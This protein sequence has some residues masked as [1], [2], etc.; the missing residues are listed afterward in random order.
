MASLL[1]EEC[2]D[3]RQDLLKEK[4]NSTNWKGQGFLHYEVVRAILTQS[5]VLAWSRQHPLCRK[6]Q[7]VCPKLSY[8]ISQITED[9]VLLFVVL[10]LSQ[11]EYLFEELEASVTDHGMLFDTKAFAQ[12]CKSTGLSERDRL[13]FYDGRLQIKIAEKYIRPDSGSSKSDWEKLLRE[14]RTLRQR[15]NHANII[16]LLAAYQQEIDESGIPVKTLHLL[17]PWGEGDLKEWINQRQTPSNVKALNRKERQNF[18]YRCIYGLVSGV[19]YLHSEIEG[20][21]T[22]HH[23]LKPGNILWVGG[24]LKIADF[25]HSHVRSVIEGS[26]T[27]GV[28]EVGTYEYHPPEYWN[29]DG[30]RSEG[31]P[32][33]D[34]DVW[35]MGC[36][37]IELLILV[38][39]GWET[40]EIARFARERHDS[41][42]P[43]RKKTE[44][45]LADDDSSF[46]NSLKVVDAWT[47]VLYE[48]RSSDHPERLVYVRM[49]AIAMLN[50]NPED[51]P[52]MWESQMDLYNILRQHD[53]QF[54]VIEKDLCVPPRARALPKGTWLAVDTP[55]HRAVRKKDFKRT[56][57]LWELGWPLSTRNGDNDRPLRMMAASEDSRLRSL[58]NDVSLMLK[59]ASDGQIDLLKQLFSRGLSPLMINKGG[60]SA[61]HQTIS[62]FQPVDSD[63]DSLTRDRLCQRNLQLLRTVEFLLETKGNDQVN[64]RAGNL[65]AGG[66]GFPL[67][68]AASKGFVEAM[69]RILQEGA[70]INGRAENDHLSPLYL[71]ASKCHPGAVKLLLEHKAKVRLY[72]KPHGTTP[73]HGALTKKMDEGKVCEVV[74]C[75]LE[76]D[77]GKECIDFPEVMMG[78]PL[79]MA[80]SLE[81]LKCCRLLTDY[82]A[83]VHITK[84]NNLGLLHAIARNGWTDFLQQIHEEFSLEELE[85]RA[86]LDGREFRAGT[87]TPAEVAKKSGHKQI[88]RL[89]DTRRHKLKRLE[90]N[91]YWPSGLLPTFHKRTKD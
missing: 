74:E 57:R 18:L 58:P 53:N 16:S 59:A 61:L 88:V 70:D 5:R 36:I 13:A 29:P 26:R 80:A 14:V 32:G 27:E 86:S 35:A 1:K 75:L 15:Q 46:H 72:S 62:S 22:T 90:S 91:V 37:I 65:W 56:V 17:F 6:H 76:A 44:R 83:S 7:G 89:L 50:V 19:S 64:L 81:Y 63:H 9:K 25:G 24:E 12:I 84:I 82:G 20:S 34:L 78:P 41:R 48:R 66:K 40:C 77:D 39:H 52:Y 45:Y 23:D 38:I 60:Q 79:M 71:A 69:R 2:G 4:A 3:L 67:Q 11:L 31:K 30:S 49:I 54:P 55:L 33:R 68:I 73:L 47:E 28:S 51:R 85:A 87:F 43:G 21:F 10:V 8:L 42:D